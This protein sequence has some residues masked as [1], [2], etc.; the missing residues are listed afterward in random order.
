MLG[1][2][3]QGPVVKYEHGMDATIDK[4]VEEG[5]LDPLCAEIFRTDKP[6]ESPRGEPL[7]LFSHQ[8]QALDIAK[9]AESYV[10]TTGIGSGA[11][12]EPARSASIR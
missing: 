7:T 12:R 2:V 9:D 1:Q 10:V 6:T 8:Q 5:G 4:L 3:S 11:S